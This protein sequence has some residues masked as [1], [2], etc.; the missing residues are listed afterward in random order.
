MARLTGKIVL[1][2]KIVNFFA[3]KLTPAAMVSEVKD[4]AQNMCVELLQ[5]MRFVVK[6][7]L[8]CQRR[9]T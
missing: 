3:T 7:F 6:P 1:I 8:M 4:R 9:A 5:L 2:M